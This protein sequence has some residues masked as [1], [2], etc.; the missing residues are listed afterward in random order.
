[1]YKDVD[2]CYVVVITSRDDV[3]DRMKFQLTV[4]GTIEENYSSTMKSGHLLSPK[5]Q[6]RLAV[7]SG[8]QG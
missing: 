8:H 1:M 4:L 7:V 5:I 6:V 3:W 2:E